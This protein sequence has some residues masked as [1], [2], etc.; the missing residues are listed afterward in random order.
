MSTWSEIQGHFKTILDWLKTPFQKALPIQ[1]ANLNRAQHTDEEKIK[2]SSEIHAEALGIPFCLDPK[3][4][5]LQKPPQ[6]LLPY[7]F[8]KRNLI[9]VYAEEDGHLFCATHDPLL[10]NAI[11]EAEVLVK[12][13][14]ELV[15]STRE[16]IL[17]TIDTLYQHNQ[18]TA[19]QIIDAAGDNDI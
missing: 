8:V 1:N 7:S 17:E 18:N 4:K 14:L 2:S 5:A 16:A 3:E 6:T 12:R 19:S 15:Y 11:E 13:P 9:V 10:L